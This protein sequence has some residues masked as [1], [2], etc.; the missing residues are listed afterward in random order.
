MLGEQKQLKALV[1]DDD[2]TITKVVARVLIK[3]MQMD[4]KEANS[5]K[6]ALSHL[7]QEIPDIIIVDYMM[8]IMTG[9]DLITLL[10][11]D[12]KFK[13]IPIIVL[14][15]LNDPEII[16]DIFSLKVDDYILKP[17]S[18][19]IIH[20]RVVKVLKNAREK[21][22]IQGSQTISNAILFIGTNK[23]LYEASVELIKNKI[24]FADFS[25][26]PNKAFNLFLQKLHK[27]VIL[28][29]VFTDVVNNLII[30]KV[31]EASPNTKLIYLVEED[32]NL[33]FLSQDKSNLPK[34]IDD[35]LSLKVSCQRLADVIQSYF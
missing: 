2:P 28:E 24:D 15:A 33:L 8:P 16:K 27:V 14:S 7:E 22:E 34:N 35:V 10:K 17:V 3:R 21:K 18:P 6:D 11:A 23:F 4:V 26:L 1:I 30:E 29:S 20:E 32:S 25:N 31:K 19:Q 12:E 5:A 9:K 13:N